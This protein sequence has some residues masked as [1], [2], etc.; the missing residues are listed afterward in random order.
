MPIS[1]EGKSLITRILH[2][3]PSFRPS[4]D[5]ILAHE[6][7]HTGNVI[8]RLLPSSTLACAPSNAM[9]KQ[10]STQAETTREQPLGNDELNNANF[11]DP[12]FVPNTERVVKKDNKNE[13]QDLIKDKDKESKGFRPNTM[14]DSSYEKKEDQ[15]DKN[16]PKDKD[17]EKGMRTL[18]MSV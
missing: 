2:L 6:F 15:G 7:F 3:N 12:K 14:R 9:L 11:Q 4:L 10:F 17:K 13:K 16:D 5:D 8:P 18:A 1:A